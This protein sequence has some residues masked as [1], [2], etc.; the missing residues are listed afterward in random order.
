MVQSLMRRRSRHPYPQMGLRSLAS[1]GKLEM[2]Q[3]RSQIFASQSVPAPAKYVQAARKCAK[4]A[5]ECVA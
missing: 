2:I 1:L 3:L 5:P 4:L